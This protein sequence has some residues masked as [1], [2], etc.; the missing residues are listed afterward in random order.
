MHLIPS[1]Y[2]ANIIRSVRFIFFYK[3]QWTGREAFSDASYSTVKL[4]II[5][6]LECSVYFVCA[7]LLCSRPVLSKIVNSRAWERIVSWTTSLSHRSSSPSKEGKEFAYEGGIGKGGMER[8][9]GRAGRPRIS[10][11]AQVSRFDPGFGDIE[12]GS[13]QECFELSGEPKEG[14]FL[15][16]S[17]DGSS[18]QSTLA[19]STTR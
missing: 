10:T 5:T 8:I 11:L 14:L 19:P 15:D 12:T 3:H 18:G 7:C 17:K 1:I 4:A 16:L 6:L 9:G 2:Q 13:R